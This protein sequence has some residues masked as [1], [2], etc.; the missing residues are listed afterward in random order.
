MTGT[1]RLKDGFQVCQQCGGGGCYWCRRQ[2]WRA[3]CPVCCNSEP[4][5]LEKNEEGEFTCLA[6]TASFEKNGE[7]LPAP[8]KT[9]KVKV[10]TK[11]A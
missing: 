9:K 3:Q 1:M 4:E 11:R 10:P 7:L 8:E 6:C 5:L 2:G